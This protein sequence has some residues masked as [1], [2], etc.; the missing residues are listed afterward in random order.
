MVDGQKQI[1]ARR[2]Q[3]AGKIDTL[4]GTRAYL[5]NNYLDRA[6]GAQVGIGANSREETLYRIYEKDAAGQALGKV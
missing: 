6:V 2:V 5:K 3:L 4:F 1:D